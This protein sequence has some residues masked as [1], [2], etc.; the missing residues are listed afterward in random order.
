MTS[1][2][3]RGAPDLAIEIGSPE[4]RR[5]DVAE[6]VGESISAGAVEVWVID[7]RT[8][9]LTVHRAGA[10]PVVLDE[11]DVLEGGDLL[12]GFLLPLSRLYSFGQ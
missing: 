9:Q 2:F 5:S 1:A 10:Q 4:D 11:Q 7:P 12:P 3:W 6:K 8:R